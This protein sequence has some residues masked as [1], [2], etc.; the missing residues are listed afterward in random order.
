MLFS[1]VNKVKDAI[2]RHEDRELDEEVGI[3][4]SILNQYWESM[5]EVRQAM[6]SGDLENAD[7]KI[8]DIA[9]YQIIVRL[10]NYLLPTEYREPIANQHKATQHEIQNRLREYRRLKSSLECATASLDRLGANSEAQIDNAITAA[11]RALDADAGENT[12]EVVQDK[13]ESE[14]APAEQQPAAAN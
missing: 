4:L 8:R 12:M 7:K 2:R 10:K 9:A 5:E 13:P 14:T 11:Q 1:C 3:V 6:I